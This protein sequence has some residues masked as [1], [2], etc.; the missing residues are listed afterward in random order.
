MLTGVIGIY[1]FFSEDE[2]TSGPPAT[3]AAA[4]AQRTLEVRGPAQVLSIEH[5]LV[6]IQA[7]SPQKDGL[8]R[9]EDSWLLGLSRHHIA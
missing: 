7:G 4:D 8:T 6:E 3:Q 5:A 2:A 1:S 9:D